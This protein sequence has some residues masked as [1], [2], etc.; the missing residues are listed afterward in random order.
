MRSELPH[1]SPS[2]L[3]RWFSWEVTSDSLHVSEPLTFE[4][5]IALKHS[6]VKQH[7]P[8]ENNR[9]CFVASNLEVCLIYVHT[10]THA[11]T[12]MHVHTHAHPRIPTHACIH[13]HARTHTHTRARALTH[14]PIR[15]HALTHARTHA[16]TFSP[17]NH[18]LVDAVNLVC[19]EC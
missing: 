9:Q 11:R 10:H 15:T 1:P 12:H 6:N 17:T 18:V 4:W 5:S 16:L 14:A 2:C 7:N 13:T 3:Q 8:K 19:S